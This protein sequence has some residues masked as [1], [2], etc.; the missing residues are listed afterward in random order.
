[1]AET[2][3][4]TMSDTIK[5]ELKKFNITD[6]A[7]QRL[8]DE[9]LPLKIESIADKKSYRE[10]RKAR[11]DIK[12]KRVAVEN[13]RKELKADALAFGRAVDNEAK[14]ITA[15]LVPIEEHLSS[16]EKWVNDEKERIKQEELRKE[17]ER[18]QKMSDALAKYG[19]AISYEL[20]CEMSQ[21]EY[22]CAL[23]E[24]KHDWEQQQ[25]KKEEEA[26]LAKMA[27]EEAELKRIAEEQEKVRKAE[28][29]PDKEKLLFF[30]ESVTQLKLPTIKDEK[31]KC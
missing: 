27:A 9:Y 2:A 20:L 14:R 16:Q 7:I 10:V 29:R 12:S 13:K 24:A 31:F 15:L 17:R 19:T 25:A 11:L 23:E 21:D 5:T 18:I 8:S 22:S 1:M 30:A 6:A 4:R 28:L 3:I 26:R